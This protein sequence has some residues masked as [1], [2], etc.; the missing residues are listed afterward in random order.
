MFKIAGKK[1]RCKAFGISVFTRKEE[2]FLAQQSQ[3]N[4]GLKFI[5]Q[6]LIIQERDGKVFETPSKGNPP[7]NPPKPS[8]KTWYPYRE[9]NETEIFTHLVDYPVTK[10]EN[11]VKD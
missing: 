7:Q 11:G 6:G 5:Y 3:I 10:N 2:A 1:T 4:S 8:H 9:I